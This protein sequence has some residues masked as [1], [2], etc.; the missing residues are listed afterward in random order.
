MSE[1]EICSIWLAGKSNQFCT[2]YRV[3]I[4]WY[5]Q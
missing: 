1:T 3:L 2:P 5:I 4:L